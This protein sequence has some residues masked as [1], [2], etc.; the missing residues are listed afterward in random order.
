MARFSI[1]PRLENLVFGLRPWVIGFFVVVT[2]FMLWSAREIGID[3]GF[4][5]L[6]PLEH[7]YMQTYV[8]HRQEFG[9]ANR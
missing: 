8:E 1:I 4:E 6:L 3:A 2:A 5:K 7:E 9:G